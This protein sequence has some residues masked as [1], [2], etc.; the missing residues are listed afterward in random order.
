M[1]ST[2]TIF[3]FW[4]SSTFYSEVCENFS[5]GAE[6]GF[7]VIAFVGKPFN[8]DCSGIFFL[9]FKLLFFYLLIYLIL[10]LFICFIISFFLKN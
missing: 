5:E 1:T 7:L 2:L 3:V 9:I 6:I 10:N 4:F 8:A